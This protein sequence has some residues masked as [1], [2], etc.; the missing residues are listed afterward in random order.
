MSKP[1]NIELKTALVAAATMK[2]HDKDPFFIAKTLLNHNFR[3]KYYEDLLIAADRYMNH[4]QAEHERMKLLKCIE[5]IK[6]EE[7][8]I[9]KRNSDSFGL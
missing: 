6:D 1:T 4:G 8:R 2:E 7:T 9:S 5:K 3:L